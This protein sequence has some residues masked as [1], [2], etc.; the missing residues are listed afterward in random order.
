MGWK[1]V[2]EHYRIE[3]FVTVQK[4]G[5]CIGTDTRS[6]L[7][8]ISPSGYVLESVCRQGN[9]E[10]TRYVAEICGDRETFQM[11]LARP[12]EFENNIPIWTYDGAE[13]I[14]KRCEIPHWPNLTHDGQMIYDHKYS[15]NRA[16]VIQMALGEAEKL[17][18]DGVKCR[19]EAYDK[20]LSVKNDVEKITKT[21]NCLYAEQYKELGVVK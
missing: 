18:E 12:D 20:F 21:L 9:K 7:L 15:T 11:L 14:E 4:D 17:F 16:I 19:S 6:R 3:H 8:V 1:A 13:I 2:K 10:L 5:L